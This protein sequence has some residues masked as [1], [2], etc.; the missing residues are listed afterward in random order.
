MKYMMMTTSFSNTMKL[1]IAAVILSAAIMIGFTL[2]SL[3][4]ANAIIM[5][6]KS[7]TNCE[8]NHCQT[9]ACI[10]NKCSTLFSTLNS[11]RE[12]LNSTIP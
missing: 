4:S 3:N 5:S 6:K 9:T 1:I 10:N 11:T 7:S 8:G 12:L 2:G